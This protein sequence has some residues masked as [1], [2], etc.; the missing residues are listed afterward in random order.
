MK[1]DAD[2]LGRDAGKIHEEILANLTD[3]P[4]V[5]AEVTMEIQVRVPEGVSEDIVRVVSENASVLKFTHAGFE[6]E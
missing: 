5:Q 3:L 6:K 4:G 2:R 1:L